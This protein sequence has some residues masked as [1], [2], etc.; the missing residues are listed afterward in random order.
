MKDTELVC[1]VCEQRI[2]PAKL[3]PHPTGWTHVAD[4]S[5]NWN[6]TYNLDCCG[7]AVPK[8]P[9]PTG[10]DKATPWVHVPHLPGYEWRLNSNGYRET[11]PLEP[12]APEVIEV[13]LPPMDEEYMQSSRE[14]DEVT[15]CRERQ[16]LSEIAAH[17]ETLLTH[18]SQ[19]KN[20]QALNELVRSLRKERDA[21]IA[22][23][24]MMK[25]EILELKLG[26]QA[27]ACE[28]RTEDACAYLRRADQLQRDLDAAKELLRDYMEDHECPN[29][30]DD[31]SC[32]STIRAR[33][34]LK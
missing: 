28:C 33:N 2:E 13:E 3:G 9:E 5:I 32:K 4:G 20:I 21:A 12:K 29:G 25:E 26:D 23:V 8:A 7:K 34:L 24:E 11:R 19:M 16:L 27:S 30:P 10:D 1:S 15:N 6:D 31:P 18:E 17:T 22:E 14:W